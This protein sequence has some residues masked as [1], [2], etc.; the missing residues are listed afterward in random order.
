MAV[1]TVPSD[2]QPYFEKAIQAYTQGSYEYAV[3]LFTFVLSYA[4]DATEARR[5]LRLAIQKQ[6]TQHPPSLLSQV[7]M[8]LVTYPVR[9]W[10]IVAQTRGNTQQATRLYEWLLSLNPRSKSLLMRLAATLA[11]SGLND[12]ALQTYEELL[13][14]DPNHVGALRKLGRLAMKRGNDPQARQCFEKILQLHPGDLESQQ[15]LRNLDALGTIKKGFG[16]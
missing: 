13:A 12:A 5:Y 3:D 9:W 10:A 14:V 11:R 8:T 4:P 7:G 15:S 2:L 1:A 16:T 6:F